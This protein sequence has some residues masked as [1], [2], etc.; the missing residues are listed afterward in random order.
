MTGRL[1]E[2]AG[3]RSTAESE[4]SFLD[5]T[6]V[7]SRWRPDNRAPT[8]HANKDELLVEEPF[9]EEI[10]HLP[11][12]ATLIAAQLGE[13]IANGDYPLGGRLPPEAEFQARFGVGR[14]T[15]LEAFKILAERGLIG[16]RRKLGTIVQSSHPISQYVHSLRDIKSILD[17]A[18]DTTLDIQRMGF[19]TLSERS[20]KDLPRTPGKRWFRIAGIRSEI[21]DGKPLCWS[22]IFIPEAYAPDRSALLAREGTIY[23]VVM[24]QYGLRLDHVEQVV[25]AILMPAPLAEIFGVKARS[26][27][28]QVK[29]RFV[30]QSDG[31]FEMTHHIYPAAR[32]SLR[33]IIRQ[34]V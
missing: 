30:A 34:R 25:E 4:T 10:R 12:K 27:A 24:G 13:A 9:D 29:R 8:L 20:S 31:V 11:Q 19:G 18:Q 26:A 21:A 28:L 2:R 14:H 5:K 6:Q 22:E 33:N 32:Y 3:R 17:F 16:R 7:H 15:I 23:E 1:N